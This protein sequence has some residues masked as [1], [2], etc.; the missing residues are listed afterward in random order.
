[1]PQPGNSGSNKTLQKKNGSTGNV[2]SPKPDS[3]Q[4]LA[5]AEKQVSITIDT[6]AKS[7]SFAKFKLNGK[8]EL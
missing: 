4:S 8:L 3:S 2:G 7:W 6:S 1:M 5:Q